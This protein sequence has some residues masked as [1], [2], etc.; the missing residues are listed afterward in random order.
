[1]KWL[2]RAACVCVFRVLG[3]VLWLI[4]ASRALTACDNPEENTAQSA[5]IALLEDEVRR[6][7]AQLTA[8]PSGTTSKSKP[9]PTAAGVTKPFAIE[10]PQPWLLQPPLG[11]T[12]WTCRSPA[13]TP[14]G[15]YP[16][17]SIVMQPQVAVELLG[18]SEFAWNASPQLRQVKNYKDKP[19]KIKDHDG[20][21]AIYEADPKPV[22][23][24]MR[25]V[26]I[27]NAEHVYAVTCFAP[28]ASFDSYDAKAFQKITNTITFP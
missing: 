2:K 3:Q 24:K 23:V 5:R 6:L 18:Y 20:F 22:S 9:P 19:L 11:A 15:F 10:C 28:S 27:P 21:E 14:E 17:C 26:L 4:T 13:P 8:L 1:M 25:S 16:H 7:G 12:I